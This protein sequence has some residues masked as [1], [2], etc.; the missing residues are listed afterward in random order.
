MSD[1]ARRTQRDPPS[2]GGGAA[3]LRGI[4]VSKSFGG[5]AAVRGVD[6]AVR[7]GEIFGVI[8]P[9]GAGKT[10]LFRL[11]SGIYRPDAGSLLLDETDIA[12]LKPHRICRMG[13]C[14][15]HQLVR[16]FG[17]LS[18]MENVLVG[19]LF[20]RG[21]RARQTGG[22]EAAREILGFMGLD[23][24]TDAP[25]RS[26][27]LAQRKRLEVARAL[28]TAP[29]VLLLDE[30]MAGLNPAETAATMDLIRAIRGRGITVF[31]VEHVMRAIMGLCDR[32]MVL[33][34]GEKLAEGTPREVVDDERV[35]TAYPGTWRAS[36]P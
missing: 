32:V 9:N 19:A 27:T 6:F 3:I 23:R 21:K 25:A 1:G 8:G 12:G 35:V 22:R 15:T 16:P 31:I 34:H 18:V 14:T 4:G 33:H 28:A 24:L 7:R 17:E 29:T 10:T 26:L 13:V 5:L 2:Q 30:V 36:N 11:I 20:G